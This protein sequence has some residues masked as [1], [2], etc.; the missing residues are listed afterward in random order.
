[1]NKVE[2]ISSATVAEKNKRRDIL[3]GARRVFRAEGFDGASM[4]KIA[5]SAKVSKGTLYVY[6]RN[7]EDLFQ[8]LVLADRAQAAEQIFAEDDGDD[9]VGAVL[10]RLGLRF[11]TVM[12]SPQHIALI[13]MVIGAAEKFPKAGRTFYETGPCYGVE[14][15]AAYLEGEVARGRL[16]IDEEAT[17]A[18]SHFL[19]MCHGNAVKA[20]LFADAPPPGKA[21]VR[22]IVESAVRVFL[23]AYGPDGI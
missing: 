21:E 20:Q 5:Q 15:L 13:R 18:A 7:K 3:D 8:E 23:R 4:D 2:A 16:R 10:L 9:E 12:T 17:M 1:M 6:F 22:R 11:L 19:N 14:K